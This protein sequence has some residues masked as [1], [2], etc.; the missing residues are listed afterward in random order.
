MSGREGRL[1]TRKP[2]AGAFCILLGLGGAGL[3]CVLMLQT[4]TLA[5]VKAEGDVRCTVERRTLLDRTATSVKGG[6]AAGVQ[7]HKRGSGGGRG[8]NYRITLRDSSHTEIVAWTNV[9]VSDMARSLHTFLSDPAA[10]R[11]EEK[12]NNFGLFFI[13]AGLGLVLVGMGFYMALVPNTWR[14]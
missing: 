10:T 6:P 5:C 11:H 7:L 3:L 9:D 12:A 8:S 14:T 2:V 13:F 4:V 1:P